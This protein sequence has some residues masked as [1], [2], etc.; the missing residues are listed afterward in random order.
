MIPRTARLAASFLPIL[1]SPLTAHA[2]KPGA[3]VYQSGFLSKE[4]AMKSIQLPDGYS[5]ELL[6]SEPL[7]NE[8][9]MTAW[10][11]NGAMYVV[12]MLTYMQDLNASGEK[13]PTSIIT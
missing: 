5:L 8:P 3:T 1:L 9:V 4:D 13:K 6:L 12:Q 10:D 2:A 11:G 7:V